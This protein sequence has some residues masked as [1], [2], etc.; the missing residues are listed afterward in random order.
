MDLIKKIVVTIALVV[1]VS[2]ALSYFVF[3]QAPQKTGEFQQF[4][5]QINET[6]NIQISNDLKSEGFIKSSWILNLILDIRGVVVIPGG[7]K[8]SKMMNVWDIAGALSKKPD[9]A[10]IVIPEGLRKEEIADILANKLGWSDSMKA[11]WLTKDTIT[12]PE[13]FEGVYFP[14]TYLI[15]VSENPLQ[16]AE[17]LQ[18]HFNEKFSV[19][20]KEA[21]QNN[22]KWT[23]ALTLASIIQREA[24]GTNDM[25]LISGILWN[26]LL[27]N[28]RLEVDS[29]LQ[30]ARGNIGNGWWAPIT[31]ADKKINSPFNTYLHAGLPPHPISNPGL[32]AISAA[33]NPQTTDCLYYI[34]DSSKTIHCS[35][36]YAGQLDN[37]KKYLVQ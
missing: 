9:L 31:A 30:Y 23:T 2:L 36:D 25:P 37:I 22:I 15:P 21:A 33:I 3:I 29:T 16:V 26:R 35:A 6:S 20:A 1:F 14:D 12:P 27:K 5:I 32:E 34:H 7:Y 24:A 28:M 17:R 19:Y 13:Y 10:W 18:K 4:T 11:E 8:L